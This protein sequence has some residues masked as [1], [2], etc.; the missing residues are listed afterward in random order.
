[1]GFFKP[2]HFLLPSKKFIG[3]LNILDL[4]LDL[5]KK[6]KPEINIL[7]KNQFKK[8]KV[9]HDIDI[10]KYDKGHVCVFGGKMPGASRIVALASRKI[11]AGLSTILIEKNNL[12]YYCNSEPG[13]II[14]KFNFSKL[15]GKNVFVIGPGLGKT[16]NTNKLYKLLSSVEQPVILDA[17]AI[18][19][20][21]N[22]KEIFYKLLNKKKNFILTPH[23]GE[24][25]RVFTYN[26]K[27]PRLKIA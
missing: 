11:G 6:L 4:K 23:Y 20:F 18:S 13:T 7:N 27:F 16:F 5:P 21:E 17:D 12:I 1:M 8:F 26:E 24:F 14:E 15:N 19:L 9:F 10:N 3:S 2:A 25:M 22:E